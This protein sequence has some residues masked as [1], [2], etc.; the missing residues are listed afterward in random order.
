MSECIALLHNSQVIVEQVAQAFKRFYPE[1]EIINIIDKD[2]QTRG[3]IHYFEVC[4]V[5][6]YSLCAEGLGTD[7]VLMI[8]SS[9]YEALF[10][11][12]LMIKIPAFAINVHLPNSSLEQSRYCSY[13]YAAECFRA[14]RCL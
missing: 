4:C 12:K 8:Y 9:L 10:T 13:W 2:I 14:N 1:A 11:S 3:R 5:C 6:R 7:A